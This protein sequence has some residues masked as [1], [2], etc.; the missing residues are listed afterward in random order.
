M[1]FICMKHLSIPL[2]TILRT[3]MHPFASFTINQV[4]TIKIKQ[5]I[6]VQFELI[7]E[8]IRTHVFTRQWSQNCPL[9]LA[10]RV[11][12]NGRH[13]VT[14]V[15][16]GRYLIL[17]AILSLQSWWDA[18]ILDSNKVNCDW[19]LRMGFV[20]IFWSHQL[21]FIHCCAFGFT[22]LFAPWAALAL[23]TEFRDGE[24]FSLP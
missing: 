14:I 13:G 22:I 24:N 17:S 9:Y 15:S 8:R 6:K 12:Q 2:Q 20:Y 16:P 23:T 21:S 7:N 18:Y 5:V 1:T 4:I 19:N 3:I 11:W 10:I